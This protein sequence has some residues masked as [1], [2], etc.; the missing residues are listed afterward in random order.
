MKKILLALIIVIFIICGIGFYYF[1]KPLDSIHGM[2]TEYKLMATELLEAFEE[3]E[4]KANADYLDKVIEVNGTVQKVEINQDRITVYLETNNL[5]SS[6]IFQMEESDGNI[7]EG[8]IVNL[9]GIC[10]GF[11]MD[12]VFVRSIKV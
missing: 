7:K 5:M 12:V 10:T 2:T 4:N 11:L 1:N 8:D 3:D 6:I 9:K